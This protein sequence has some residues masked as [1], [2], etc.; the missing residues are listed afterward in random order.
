[1]GVDR[2]PRPT[3][4]RLHRF[5]T[6]AGCL[7]R[8]VLVVGRIPL[9]EKHLRHILDRKQQLG[10]Q[11]SAAQRFSATHQQCTAQAPLDLAPRIS[12]THQQCTA[13]APLDA[14]GVRA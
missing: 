5:T 11:L 3:T 6:T 10:L 2:D 14:K 12:A 8:S 9:Q 7:R 4:P 13:Q 1:M